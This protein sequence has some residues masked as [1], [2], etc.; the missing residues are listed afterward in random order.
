MAVIS[1]TIVESSLQILAGIPRSLTVEANVPSTIFYTLDGTDPGTSS[2]VYLSELILP[3]NSDTVHVKFW[4]S[5]GSDTSTIISLDFATNIVGARVPHVKVLN[6]DALPAVDYFPFGSNEQ[7]ELPIFGG[8]AGTTVDDPNIV[9]IPDGYDGT[10]TGTSPGGTDEPLT[11]YSFIYSTTNA[12]GEV[13]NRIGTLPAKVSVRITPPPPIS[14]NPNDRLF[15]PKAMVIYQDSREEVLDPDVPQLNKQYFSNIDVG[16]A[17]DGAYLFQTGY[18]NSQVS[19]SFINA[20]VNP[21]DQTVTYYYRDSITGQ[22][23]ISKEPYSPSPD[24]KNLSNIVYSDRY[25]RT[26]MPWIPY[27]RR[28]HG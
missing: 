17:R 7:L 28:Y 26:V 18:E 22:W 9:N 16:T 6:A 8:V 5:N 15:N 19:G 24:A 27:F 14:S 11:N 4:A 23:I 13:G 10:G 2:S 20:H 12:K 3:T 1:L 21:R 25:E